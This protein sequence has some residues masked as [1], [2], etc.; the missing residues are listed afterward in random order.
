MGKGFL[1][2]KIAP[3]TKFGEGDFRNIVPRFK[4]ENLKANQAFV[5]LLAKVA[6]EKEATTGQVALAWILA[7]KPWIVP[8]PGTTKIERVIENARAAEVKL[9]A[10]ELQV[11]E[12]AAAK[13]KAQGERYPEFL[14]KRIDR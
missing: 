1:T 6:K 2:G 14:Q 3:D 8:I 11:I 9:T 10:D 7:Q 4:E 5:D 12:T 13:I